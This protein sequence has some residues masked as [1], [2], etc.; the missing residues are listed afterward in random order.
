M[1]F[2]RTHLGPWILSAVA[3]ALGPAVAPAVTAQA[4]SGPAWRIVFTHHYG[5]Q[6]TGS[7]YLAVTAAGKRA[8]WAVGTAGGSGNPA[9]GRPAAARWRA[10]SWRAAGLPGG[11]SGALGAVS[12]DSTRDA[13]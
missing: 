1:S 3:L 8:A 6:A 11:L 4:A 13:W 10:R 9:T 5:G 2:R 7:T 12:A